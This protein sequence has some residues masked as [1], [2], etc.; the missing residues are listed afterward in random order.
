MACCA[1]LSDIILLK[2]PW[3]ALDVRLISAA[4]VSEP[5]PKV[6]EQ[7]QYVVIQAV[8]QRDGVDDDMD[9]HCPAGA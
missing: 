7:Y 5:D 3:L 9:W 4:E 6:V 2:S 8:L 1:L